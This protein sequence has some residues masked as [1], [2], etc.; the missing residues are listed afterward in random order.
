MTLLAHRSTIDVFNPLTFQTM[1]QAADVFIRSRMLPQS[2]QTPEQAIVIMLKGQELGLQPLQALNGIN[3]IQGKPT[4]SPQLMLSLINCSGKLEDIRFELGPDFV[5]FT[6]KR[7]GRSKHTERFGSREA[8]SMG[9]AGK[10]NYKRQPQVMYKWRAVAACARV[11][12]PDVI[13]GL[14]TPEEMGADVVVD[15]DGGLTLA[16]EVVPATP[17]QQEK[18]AHQ[19]P[20][21]FNARHYREAYFAVTQGTPYAEDKGRAKL[22]HHLTSLYYTEHINQIT[23]SLSAVLKRED[24]ELA[25]FI[26]KGAEAA[27]KKHQEAQQQPLTAEQVQKLTGFLEE[28]GITDALGFCQHVLQ[29]K[30]SS[31]AD[32][33][34]GERAQIAKAAK[35]ATKTQ[36]ATEEDLPF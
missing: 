21:A 16:A 6:M 17:V 32:V 28:N 18:P 11:T 31:L 33:L 2:I 13:D 9:L 23:E 26:I 7:Y 27:V 34:A 10:D 1:L 29:R 20:Q 8:Q 35:E 24:H 22:L 3:A 15:E 30:L 12:F 36:E 25:Q 4:V 5:A 19:K 14:Y